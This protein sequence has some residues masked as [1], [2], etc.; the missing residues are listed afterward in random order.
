MEHLHH[1]IESDHRTFTFISDRNNGLINAIKDW[2]PGHPHAYCYHHLKVNIQSKFPGSANKDTRDK[3]INLFT[4]CA[5]TYSKKRFNKAL[6]ELKKEGGEVI[7]NFLRTLPFK[8]WANSYFTG[9]RYG[10]MCSNIVESFNSMV[11]EERAL[12]I[13]Q[14]IDGIRSRLMRFI[15]DRSHDASKWTSVLCPKFEKLLNAHV[16]AGEHWIVN[17]SSSGVYEVLADHTCKVDLFA[18]NCYEVLAH[19]CS[20]NCLDS[21]VFTP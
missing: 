20:G 3:V 16:K 21:L 19:A 1:I 15:G 6:I 8:N 18:R 10:E 17:R 2:F 7:E 5:Y 14:L 4:V 12:P 11:L 9:E 13:T